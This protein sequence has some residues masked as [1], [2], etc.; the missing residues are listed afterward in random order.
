MNIPDDCLVITLGVGQVSENFGHVTVKYHSPGRY[1]VAF[2]S[3]VFNRFGTEQM[4]I[5]SYPTDE[6]FVSTFT[7]DFEQAVAIGKRVVQEKRK[8][9]EQRRE[10][11]A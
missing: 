9:L 1:L 8:W 2:L 3:S 6:P 11:K 5:G 10:S 7:F 4:V